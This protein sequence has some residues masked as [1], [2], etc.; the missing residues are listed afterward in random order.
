M[1]RI[2]NADASP[3]RRHIIDDALYRNPVTFLPNN[4]I[5]FCELL[6]VAIVVLLLCLPFAHSIFWLGD[7]GVL[8]HGAERLLRGRKLYVD[9]FEFLPPGGF[10]I[11]MGWFGLT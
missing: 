10:I 3:R 9:F 5:G 4:W 11:V 8:V 6:F 7:E 2:M 1:L